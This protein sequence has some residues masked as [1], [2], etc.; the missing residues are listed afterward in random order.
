MTALQAHQ[1]AALWA[2]A[3]ASAA[4]LAVL[5]HRLGGVLLRARPG[6][7]RDFWL[8][9][10]RRLQGTEQP[11]RKLP[12]HCGEGRLLGGLDLAATLRSGRPVAERGLL[13]DC[14]GGVLLL[15]MAE[16]A[17]GMLLAN[18][19]AVLDFGE[20]RVER[21][22]VAA[23]LPARLSLIALD[24]GV[25]DS[26]MLG[27]SLAERL[28]VQID[29]D[30]LGITALDDLP[31]SREDVLE[32]RR[33]CDTLALG[34][35]QMQ[36]LCRLTLALGVHSPRAALFAGRVA[37]AAAALADRE[38]VVD[39]D[40]Q[41]ALRL[42]LLPRATQL[43]AAEEVEES[44]E[45]ESPPEPPAPEPDD[46]GGDQDREQAPRE[47]VPAERLLDAARAVLP[48]A[49]LEQLVARAVRRTGSRAGGGKS[50]ARQRHKLRGRPMGSR[51]GDPRSGARLDLIATL[52]AA[53]P[54][55]RLRSPPGGARI[56]VESD[57]FRVVRFRQRTPSVTVFVVDAS[58]SAAL[59][60]LAEAKGAVELLLND[61]YVRR[62]EVA[63]VAFRGSEAE[64]LLPPT[65]SLVRAKRSLSALP[66]GGGTPL[67]SAIEVTALLL[68]QIERRGAT[69]AYVMLT[70]G[71]ANI[72]RDG[73]P[74]RE[75]AGIDALNAAAQLRGLSRASGLVIDTSPRPH[76]AAAKLAD[77]LAATYLPLPHADARQLQAAVRGAGQGARGRE[78]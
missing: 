12:L 47:G 4:L 73:A 9:E 62:D 20:L 45:Q 64:I 67:A 68:E 14:D 40:L 71:R 8:Q 10:C 49:L 70:D 60:R 21:E 5:G 16:R 26:E 32:A 44:A 56:R 78:S 69:P 7:V 57:D 19:G 37:I 27:A 52:R 76:R 46:P 65:R 35:T 31:L 13:A 6:P 41:L 72:A 58:G 66:G 33:R 59:Y 1:Q 50:G 61:C 2:D 3:A 11:W 74:G 48:P 30:P 42:V 43:P 38:E 75:Q 53:A 23:C 36:T 18:L 51:A 25:D 55:Q 17:E 77:A 29:L 22:G 34:D 39:E 15:P 63:L 28:G 24:E 54:W